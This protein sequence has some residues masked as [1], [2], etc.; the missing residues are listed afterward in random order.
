ML[1]NHIGMM[2]SGDKRFLEIGL[3]IGNSVATQ[4]RRNNYLKGGIESVSITESTHG[5]DL[6][7]KWTAW[8]QEEGCRRMGFSCWVSLGL[9]LNLRRC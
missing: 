3:V 9:T 7:A 4:C 8:I 6:E 2:Y 5:P 1:L